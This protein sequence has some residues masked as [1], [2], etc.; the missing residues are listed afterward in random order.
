MKREWCRGR[1]T[2]WC[3]ANRLLKDNVLFLCSYLNWNQTRY[4][5]RG[6]LP[7]TASPTLRLLLLNIKYLPL[8]MARAI[9]SRLQNTWDLRHKKKKHAFWCPG[10]V[11]L[12]TRQWR[13]RFSSSEC[14]LVKK[15]CPHLL[16][17][18]CFILHAISYLCKYIVR[19]WRLNEEL[20][21]SRVPI[22]FPWLCRIRKPLAWEKRQMKRKAHLAAHERRSWKGVNLTQL[23]DSGTIWEWQTLNRNTTSLNE[24]SCEYEGWEDEEEDGRMNNKEDELYGRQVSDDDSL[25]ALI[26]CSL[27]SSCSSPKYTSRPC[28]RM[29]RR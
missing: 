9:Y 4:L 14:Y 29:F 10:A 11:R 22:Q 15:I 25:E 23:E 26:P 19:N 13:V 27:S 2:R 1:E 20:V 21:S 17:S 24:D 12:I 16:W 8:S 5:W 7:C 6:K 28:S 3:H 18:A